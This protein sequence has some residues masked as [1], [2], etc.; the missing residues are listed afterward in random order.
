MRSALHRRS[1]QERA[2]NGG[3]GGTYKVSVKA[4]ANNQS[5]SAM[6]AICMKITNS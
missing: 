4:G 2:A 6:Y 5:V 3:V 1:T